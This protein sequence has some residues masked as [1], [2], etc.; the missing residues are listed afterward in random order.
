MF[1]QPALK[2]VSSTNCNW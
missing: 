2:Q 1:M